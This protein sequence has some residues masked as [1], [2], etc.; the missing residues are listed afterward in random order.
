MPRLGCARYWRRSPGE[1]PV[2]VNDPA[3]IHARR[4]GDRDPQR[5]LCDQTSPRVYRMLVRRAGN[6]ED[7]FD[8]AQTT[9][10]RVFECVRRL[11]D[12]PSVDTWI[13]RI[14]VNDALDRLD[15]DARAILLRRYHEGLD[16]EPGTVASRLNRARAK[17]R[18]L[19][20]AGCGVAGAFPPDCRNTR[21]RFGEST[22]ETA[23]D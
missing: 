23:S 15:P 1:M 7:A 19:L 4:A 3:L 5:R 20:A 16:C 14:A 22:T 2:S 21:T 17:T 12:R 9:Y 6:P 18:A 11:D 10:L 13:Y 8:L